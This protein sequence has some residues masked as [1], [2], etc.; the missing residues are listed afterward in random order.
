MLR[1]VGLVV[2]WIAANWLICTLLGGKGKLKEI[3]IVTCY[4]LLPLIVEGIIHIILSNVLLPVEASFLS[5]LSV[6]SL[7]YFGFMLVIGMLKIHDFGMG[8]FLWTSFLA[9]L[10]MAIIVFLIIML[11]I[12]VQQFGAFVATLITELS[13][14]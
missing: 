14:I 3:I 2:I 12:L 7:I 6:I 8:K 13:T 1:S 5:I 9:V 11:I 4:S 10:G